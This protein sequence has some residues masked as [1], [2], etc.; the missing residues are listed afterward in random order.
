MPY[1][2]RGNSVASLAVNERKEGL[3]VGQVVQGVVT[4]Q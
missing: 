2:G 4:E 3:L 1:F